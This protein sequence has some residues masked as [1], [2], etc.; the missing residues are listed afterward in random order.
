MFSPYYIKHILVLVMYSWFCILDLDQLR[1]MS[2]W[3]YDDIQYELA[4]YIIACFQ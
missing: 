3:G 1:V 2:T 4:T